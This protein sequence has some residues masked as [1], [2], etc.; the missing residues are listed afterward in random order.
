MID[1]F[2]RSHFVQK[3]TL[4]IFCF[5]DWTIFMKK[6]AVKCVAYKISV[7]SSWPQCLNNVF[8]YIWYNKYE[9]VLNFKICS[10][11]NNTDESNSDT[12]PF[13]RIYICQKYYIWLAF[14][15]VIKCVYFKPNRHRFCPYFNIFER[16]QYILLFYWWRYLTF[17]F[18]FMTRSCVKLMPL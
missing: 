9:F 12:L 1:L 13:Y 5:K 17:V 16:T 10:L 2:E 18:M 3:F 14:R 15:S 4:S 7:I 6:N 8:H 11:R